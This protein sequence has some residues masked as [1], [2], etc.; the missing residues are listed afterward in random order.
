MRCDLEAKP[1]PDTRDMARRR[2]LLIKLVIHNC[3]PAAKMKFEAVTRLRKKLK[4]GDNV[5]GM[6]VSLKDASTTEIATAVGLDWVLIDCEHGE[7][8]LHLMSQQKNSRDS[9]HWL[10]D[11][12]RLL[13]HDNTHRA[14]HVGRHD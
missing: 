3:C 12:S 7:S 2:S 14:P 13:E 10:T 4:N 5:L 8:F 1:F 6:F 11:S 9:V